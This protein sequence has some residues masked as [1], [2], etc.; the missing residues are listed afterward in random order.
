MVPALVP[1]TI[2]WYVGFDPPLTGVAVKLT[3]EPGQNGFG[4]ATMVAPAGGLG[5]A[6]I[7]MGRAVAGLP[8]THGSLEVRIQ[9]TRSRDAGLYE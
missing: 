9:D 6:V 4:E 1:L 8:V 2:H 3:G 7:R 5:L